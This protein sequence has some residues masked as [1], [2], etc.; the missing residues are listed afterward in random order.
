MRRAPR[1]HPIH[2]REKCQSRL[3]HCQSRLPW[4]ERAHGHNERE[5]ITFLRSG[6]ITSFPLNLAQSCSPALHPL[7][8]QKNPP[9]AQAYLFVS[10]WIWS[11]AYP[12][13]QYVWTCGR[14]GQ[15][16][17]VGPLV[18]GCMGAA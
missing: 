11:D 3:S 1:R 15:M 14:G 18:A 16:S 12:R 5:T 17:G 2:L 6:P 9:L 8:T 13:G 10:F 7:G 4:T